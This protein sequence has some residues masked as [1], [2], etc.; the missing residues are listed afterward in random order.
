MARE[1]RSPGIIF[2]ETCFLRYH[3]PLREE[4][5]FRRRTTWNA[6]VTLHSDDEPV[7]CVYARVNLTVLR[8]GRR[9]SLRLAVNDCHRVGWGGLYIMVST[10]AELLRRWQVPGL[11]GRFPLALVEMDG[12]VK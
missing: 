3:T 11:I 2:A 7:G 9:Q 4:K 6:S 1:G 12:Q 10:T 8:G 5:P